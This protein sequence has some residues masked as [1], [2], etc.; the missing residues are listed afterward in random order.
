MNWTRGNGKILGVVLMMLFVGTAWNQ[1][2]ATINVPP[3]KTDYIE[4]T[5]PGIWTLKQDVG[6]TIEIAASNLTLDG[7]GKTVSGEGT[8][9][10]YG[11]KIIGQTEVEVRN[12]NVRDFTTGIFVQNFSTPYQ[13]SLN[14][15]IGNTV[16]NNTQYGISLSWSNDNT[17]EDNI[18]NLNT[19][20]GIYL[21]SYCDR[22][23]ISSNTVDSNG[24][25]GIMLSNGSDNNELFRNIISNNPNGIGLIDSGEIAIYNNNFVDNTTQVTGSGTSNNT[26]SMD[27]PI[28]GNYWSD[29]TGPDENPADG[30][31]DI[32]RTDLPGGIDELPLVEP[33]SE[34]KFM[35]S[36][37]IAFFDECLLKEPPTILA[38]DSTGRPA[39]KSLDM[40][41]GLL[42]KAQELILAEK[43]DL[44]CKKLDKT[45]AGGDGIKPPDMIMDNPDVEGNDL[46][47]LMGMIEALTAA[48]ACP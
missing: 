3:G 7:D 2:L 39:E 46:E 13:P 42:V 30:F 5:S 18:T 35:I 15:L 1:V 20:Y 10:Q 31:I 6:E 25:H 27:S 36:S 19:T 47:T 24:S 4:E 32:A 34:I 33:Y 9:A 28:G 8:T 48:L 23:I 41:K 29:Y 11:V 37:I 26:Y 45:L 14:R 43:Y 16:N 17:I 12:L 44:A 38:S 22:N 21:N 40:F